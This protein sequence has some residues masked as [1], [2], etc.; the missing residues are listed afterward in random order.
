VD[1]RVGPDDAGLL[2][3]T[4]QLSAASRLQGAVAAG[5]G[6]ALLLTGQAGI[7]KTSVL[8]VAC[9]TAAA[10]GVGL[11]RAVGDPLEQGYPWG[12]A[13]Q[14]LRPVL[15]RD[16]A[17][18]LL[19]GGAARARPLLEA[20]TI[21]GGP[22]ADP[23]PLLHALHWLVS[24]LADRHPVLVVVDDAHWA[25]PQSLRLLCYLLRRIADLPVGLLVSA[26][27][28]EAADGEVTT[29]L[30]RIAADPLSDAVPVPALS[31][32]A[33]G[34]IVRRWRPEAT[35]TFCGAV[36]RA[37]AGNP[38]LCREVL[39]AVDAEGLAPGDDAAVRLREMRPAGVRRTLLVRLAHLG[40]A[41]GDVARTVAVL[42]SHATTPVVADV[43][44]LPPDRA[45]EGLDRLIGAGLL[46][47]AAPQGGL[48][49]THPVVREVVLADLGVARSR[50]LH[51]RAAR[52]LAAR[53]AVPE[54]VASHLLLGDHVHEPW[55]VAALRAAAVH[56]RAAA[57]SHQAVERLRL[58]AATCSAAER[59]D[60]LVEL[61]AAEV[62][63]GEPEA[64][65]HF[66]AAARAAGGA[67]DPHLQLMLGDALYAAG[68]FREAAAA[69]EAGLDALPQD[70]GDPV[71]EAL[72]LAGLDNAALMSRRRPHRLRDRMAALAAD[73]PA[74]PHPADRVLMAAA[75]GRH[76]LA[77]DRPREEVLRL[78]TAALAG[79][80]LPAVLGRAVL[81]PVTAALTICDAFAPCLAVLDGVLEGASRRGEVAAYAGL[82]PIRA[83]CALR[84]GDLRSAA[85]DAEDALRL[86]ADLP[87]A[88]RQALAPARRVLALVALARDDDEGAAAAVAVT[89]SADLWGDSPIYGWFLDA[90]GQVALR[91]GEAETA[92]EAF[93]AAGR[94]FTTAGGPGPFCAWRSGAARALHR[95]DRHAE[96]AALVAEELRLARAA[97]VPS[98]VAIA[99]RARAEL[100]AADRD[101]EIALLGEAAA[102][103]DGSPARLEVARTDVA[104]GAALRRAGRR[105]DCRPPLRRGLDLAQRCGATRL[106][107]TAADELAA[108][109]ATR[110]DLAVT[111]PA[112]LTPSELRVARLVAEGLSN[113]QV[114][115]RLFV[116]RKTVELHLSGT[117]RKLAITSRDQLRGALGGTGWD[118]PPP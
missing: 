91:Q 32:A 34:E 57:A 47:A 7:G 63:A 66:A 73:P 28:G 12:L 52:A 106:Q 24:D 25:D 100:C 23:F 79:V 56:A 107:R 48:A 76:A 108:S 70:G 97:Q 81:E 85:A 37:V 65:E 15:D 44:E 27:T 96:A 9:R 80:D 61:G 67:V 102:V 53:G 88:P 104:L 8:D 82:L 72:L 110:P 19:S 49:F 78:A 68:R 77:G 35:P 20:G 45:A 29:L 105:R 117:Y 33:I 116:T 4:A 83:V 69:F 94:T 118:A 39:A 71:D 112:A 101:E 13:V 5:R 10:E 42:G 93:T 43:A 55:A 109:G 14:L 6:G 89:G 113:R 115:E 95:L 50:R 46:D 60:V 17:A 86:A 11:L 16:D 90:V 1:G 22:A 21:Q 98:A 51:A 114:A 74:D 59:A 18:L 31:P 111:G 99:L 87:G 75:A 92:H 62:A 84:S 26:R 40:A 3:R 41:V 36:V 30:D 58:A 54:D 64:A 38:L 103:L 2:E